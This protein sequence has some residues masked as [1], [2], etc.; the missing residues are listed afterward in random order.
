MQSRRSQLQQS[1]TVLR[2]AIANVS[3]QAITRKMPGQFNQEL[4]PHL[5]GQNA[6]SSN[7]EAMT[8]PLGQGALLTEPSPQRQDPIHKDQLRHPIQLHQR[9]MHGLLGSQ[10]NAPAIDF[11]R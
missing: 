4:I 3:L 5:L 11:S 9:S 10:A 7:G 8:I 6:C 1:S 2:S